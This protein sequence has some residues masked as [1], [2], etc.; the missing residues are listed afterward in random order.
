VEVAG[1][2]Q[3][4]VLQPSPRYAHSAGYIRDLAKQSGFEI[5]ATGEGPIREDQGLP[6]PGLFA[7]LTRQ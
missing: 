3:E 6:I 4:L 5:S 1:A 7:W 2:G